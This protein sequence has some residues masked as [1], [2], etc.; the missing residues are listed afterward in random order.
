MSC[1]LYKVTLFIYIVITNLHSHGLCTCVC[2]R[3]CDG[4][5]TKTSSGGF[6]LYPQVG[7][8][9]YLPPPPTLELSPPQVQYC[10]IRGVLVY[11]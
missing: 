3:L 4:S 1:V 11:L 2:E 9:I 6:P 8:C 5:S 7:F 10:K